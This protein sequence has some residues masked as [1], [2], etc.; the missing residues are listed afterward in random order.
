MLHARSAMQEKKTRTTCC[1][2][3]QGC[4][5]SKVNQAQGWQKGLGT[6]DAT[7]AVGPEVYESF[8]IGWA[9]TKDGGCDT[10]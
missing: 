8:P 3:I 2:R 7:V 9:F 1:G 5:W 6:A 10:A 4:D